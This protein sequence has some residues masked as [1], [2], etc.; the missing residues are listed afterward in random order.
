MVLQLIGFD[1]QLCGI[2]LMAD[3]GRLYLK[4]ILEFFAGDLLLVAHAL[5]SFIWSDLIHCLVVLFTSD[6][7]V[8]AGDVIVKVNGTDVHRFTTKEGELFLLPSRPV[9]DMS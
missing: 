8:E 2:E 3:D 6:F 7:Q 5:F 9:V 1:D 4:W